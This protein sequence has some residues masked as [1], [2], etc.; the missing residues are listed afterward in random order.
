MAKSWKKQ[1]V[2]WIAEQGREQ[3]ATCSVSR[4]DAHRRRVL[5]TVV[6]NIHGG[7]C[8]VAKM[9]TSGGLKTGQCKGPRTTGD[10]LPLPS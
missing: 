8:N 10:N 1:V 6:K 3:R 7:E 5:G 4:T 9:A 2:A